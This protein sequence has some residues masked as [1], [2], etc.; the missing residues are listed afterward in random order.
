MKKIIVFTIL[1]CGTI[2]AYSQTD[3]LL[4][5]K[6]EQNIIENINSI[7]DILLN[8]L[9][10]EK[11]NLDFRN[12]YNKDTLALHNQIK[13]LR[14]ELSSEKQK[15]LDL[16]KNIVKEE[17]D[18]LRTKVD[19]LKIA[20]SHQNKTIEDKER[21]ITYEQAKAQASAENAKNKG[22]AEVLANIVN[23][24]KNKS[25][26]DLIKSSTKESLVRDMQVLGNNPEVNSVLNDLQIYFNALEL[27]SNKFDGIQIN[28]AQTQLSQIKRQSKMLDYL[29]ENLEFYKD[30]NTALKERISSLVNLDSKKLAG[31]DSEIQKLKFKDIINIL[32]D[33]MYD[34]YD[35][36][37]YPYLSDIVSEIIKRKKFNADEE[38]TDLLKKL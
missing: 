36:A 26:D 29:K 5:K 38:I 2:S 20:I 32:S 13:D 23:S 27:L 33:Y 18:N 17:R 31:G 15:V 22:K 24:Y 9:Q 10:I 4:L 25:F 6:F 7:K 35:Y 37:K 21:Q 11:K 14:I 1:F 16:N 19:S 8:D 30:F 12:A 28:N 34:Y 3:S